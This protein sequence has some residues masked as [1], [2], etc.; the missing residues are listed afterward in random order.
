MDESRLADIAR[1]QEAG[2]VDPDLEP[3]DVLTT[4]IALSVTWSPASTT[5]AATR[6]EDKAEQQRRRDVLT[7]LVGRA[8]APTL[9]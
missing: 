9:V 7:K 4:V 8:F 1:A 3:F 6:N 2:L 5:Y